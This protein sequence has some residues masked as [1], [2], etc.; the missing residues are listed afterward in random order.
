MV[1]LKDSGERKRNKN[2]SETA[3]E[4]VKKQMKAIRISIL[5]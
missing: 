2:V 1:D 3:N 5:K 4:K